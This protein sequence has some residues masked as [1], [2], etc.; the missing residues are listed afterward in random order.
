MGCERWTWCE[1]ISNL[2]ATVIAINL[3][4]RSSTLSVAHSFNKT[5]LLLEEA[6]RQLKEASGM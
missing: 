2:E 1:T 6:K 5:Q 3:L 4:L